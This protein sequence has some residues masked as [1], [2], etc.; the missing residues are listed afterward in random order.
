[1]WKYCWLKVV[2]LLTLSVIK[3]YNAL[4]VGKIDTL[5]VIK[6][7]KPLNLAENKILQ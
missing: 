6:N 1:M 3:N 2:F 5:S 7:Y 4:K